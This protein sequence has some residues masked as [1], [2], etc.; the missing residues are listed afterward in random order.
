MKLAFT[1]NIKIC[2]Y[3]VV[4]RFKSKVFIKESLKK[5]FRKLMKSGW[6]EGF[7]Y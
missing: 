5:M 1:I 7:R 6:V 3:P 4:I 2:I